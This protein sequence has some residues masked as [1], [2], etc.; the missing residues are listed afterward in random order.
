[1]G[2]NASETVGVRSVNKEVVI[3]DKT[4]ARGKQRHCSL[5]I[6]VAVQDLQGGELDGFLRSGFKL[7]G[8]ILVGTNMLRSIEGKVNLLLV[9]GV[10]GYELGRNFSDI[11][12]GVVS[13]LINQGAILETVV[14]IGRGRTRRK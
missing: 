6:I 12:G 10:W 9:V 14:L 8:V 13:S 1:M 7:L 11:K 5:D 4:A 3:D 2:T